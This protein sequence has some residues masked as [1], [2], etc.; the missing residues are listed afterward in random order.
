[1]PKIPARYLNYDEAPDFNNDEIESARPI[2]QAQLGAAK[3]FSSRE[4]YVK[5]LPKNI[6]YMEI[7]VAWG[8]YSELVC[9]QASPSEIVLLDPFNSDLKC[10][11]WRKFG[12]CKCTNM[13]HELLFTP[14]TNEEY[15]KT[16]FSKYGPTR[17]IKGLAPEDLPEEH[18]YDYIYIDMTNDR[19]EIRD[20]LK[21]TSSMVRPGGV[22]GLNDYL[23]YDG[24]IE[25]AAYGT[26]QAVNEFLFFN[27]NWNVD[28]MALHPVGF[29]DIYLRRMF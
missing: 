17:T 7:G 23:I 22:I 14:E 20:V 15:I 4:E 24:V 27:Q 5:S 16:L 1:M 3:I 29:Y 26:F 19:V 11:S 28:A 12:E 8:Y 6:K 18:D 25:D 9:K 13:K 10:W 21:Q 2:S